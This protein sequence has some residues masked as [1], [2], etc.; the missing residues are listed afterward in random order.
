[1]QKNVYNMNKIFTT[2]R[3]FD[4]IIFGISKYLTG[5]TNE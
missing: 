3:M 1:M 2:E 4:I 5:V